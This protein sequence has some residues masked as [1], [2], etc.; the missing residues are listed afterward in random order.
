M[1]KRKKNLEQWCNENNRRELLKQWNKE[2]NSEL[3]IPMTPSTQSDAPRLSG[4]VLLCH[5]ISMNLL[6]RAFP[7]SD[8]D[9]EGEEDCSYAE[10]LSGTSV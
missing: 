3:C 4:G 10:A 2:K 8:S 1:K 6:A 9:A 5:I 7:V